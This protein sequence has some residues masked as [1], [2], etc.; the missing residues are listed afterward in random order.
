[1]TRKVNKRLSL[2][3]S[4]AGKNCDREKCRSKPEKEVF[5]SEKVGIVG[6]IGVIRKTDDQ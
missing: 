1:M 5:E 6:R 4:V 3:E 2:I